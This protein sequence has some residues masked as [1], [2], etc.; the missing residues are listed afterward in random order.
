[1]S[2]PKQGNA[3]VYAL[4]QREADAGTSQVVAGQI[5]IAHTFAYTLIDSGALLL[6]CLLYL[7]RS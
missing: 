7:L 4:T 3:R 6:S 5:S 2:T 1:M